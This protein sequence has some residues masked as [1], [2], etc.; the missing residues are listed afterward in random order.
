MKL[1]EVQKLLLPYNKYPSEVRL[2]YRFVIN[3]GEKY[4]FYFGADHY[5]PAGDS[6]Y[7]E[8]ENFWIEFLKV[9]SDQ[10]KIVFNEGGLR[11]PDL[12]KKDLIENDSEAGFIT[13]LATKDGVEIQ[14]PE[15]SRKEVETE[16]ERSFTREQIQYYFFA[17]MV[18]QWGKKQ[19]LKPNFEDYVTGFMDSDQDESAWTDFDFSLKNMEVIHE[20]IFKEKFNKDDTDF[21]Y[22]IINPITDKSIVNKI[23]RMVSQLRDA[24]MVSEIYKN[25]V[26][27]RSVFV[28]YGFGHAIVQKPAL[29][30]LLK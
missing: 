25:W 21:F 8:I 30:S 10:P 16:L 4:L 13:F 2:P 9:T 11:S 23:A 24:Y 17:Q 29:E 1:S 20:E 27:G 18:Y 19:D 12:N 15:I 6:Q 5:R 3:V 7:D 22:S 28:V 26:K 14:S